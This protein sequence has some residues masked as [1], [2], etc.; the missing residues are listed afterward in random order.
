MAMAVLAV[1][2][3]CPE[4]EAS[5]RLAEPA[6]VGEAAAAAARRAAPAA[7]A[8]RAAAARRVVPVSTLEVR[9]GA[10][11]AGPEAAVPA[12]ARRYHSTPRSIL[13]APA[14]CTSTSWWRPIVRAGT[15]V[16]VALQVAVLEG[17]LSRSKHTVP[18][19]GGW[20][21][22][23]WRRREPARH[24]AAAGRGSRRD[25]WACGQPA[26]PV[27]RY[28]E[29]S[30][31]V[32][33]VGHRLRRLRV[34]SV[35]RT[36]GRFAFSCATLP[37]GRHVVQAT[38]GSRRDRRSWTARRETRAA[39]AALVTAAAGPTAAEKVGEAS[40]AGGRGGSRRRWRLPEAPGC[41][42]HLVRGKAASVRGS[43]RLEGRD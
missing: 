9:E 16:H 7:P 12:S 39:A 22:E 42:S 31:S 10:A 4:E 38:A 30:S 26:A 5:S 34:A 33:G 43:K 21:I 14:A 3:G 23:G 11:R 13:A 37:E 25:R 35:R 18:G 24:L 2:A 32:R 36:S 8:P 20:P 41:R 17:A 6:R 28:H 1:R 19:V 40:R 27:K 29:A 15:H